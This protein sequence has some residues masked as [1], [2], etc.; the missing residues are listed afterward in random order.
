MP[1]PCGVFFVWDP[2]AMNVFL[3]PPSIKQLPRWSLRQQIV[4]W[5]NPI[6]NRLHD[7]NNLRVGGMR[8]QPFKLIQI[9]RDEKVGPNKKYFV[10]ILIYGSATWRPNT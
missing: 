1:T 2:Y 5:N 10:N 8:R 9:D 6:A 4:P 7:E 3:S